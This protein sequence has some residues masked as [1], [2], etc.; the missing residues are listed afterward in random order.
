MARHVPGGVADAKKQGFAAPDESW[1]RGESRTVLDNAIR[2]ISE[3]FNGALDARVI[4]AAAFDH[5]SG[6]RN[7]RLLMW[8]LVYLHAWMR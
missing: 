3:L 8:S 7:R 4:Q 6:G 5:T 1:F 2:E